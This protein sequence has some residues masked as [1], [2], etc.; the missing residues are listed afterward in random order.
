MQIREKFYSDIT[1]AAQNKAE[2]ASAKFIAAVTSYDHSVE[3]IARD[4]VSFWEAEYK[5]DNTAVENAE[6]FFTLYCFFIGEFNKEQNFSDHDWQQLVSSVTAAQDELDI[7]LLNTY[8][9]CF[10]ERGVL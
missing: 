4:M 7:D 3:C 10:L 1:R 8:L 6:W 9:A 2:T 5:A